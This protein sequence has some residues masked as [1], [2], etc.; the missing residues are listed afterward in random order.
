M[1][2]KDF[3]Y[4]ININCSAQFFLHGGYRF[5][6]N[7]AGDDVFKI[8]QVGIYVKGQ[9]MHGYPA[10]TTHAHGANFVRGKS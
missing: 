2:F 4:F 6:I 9:P 3:F 5:I 10:A 8:I 7:T 1:V